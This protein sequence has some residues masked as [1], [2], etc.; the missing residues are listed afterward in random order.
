MKFS[1]SIT[2]IIFTLFLSFGAL[3]QTEFKTTRNLGFKASSKTQ[4][5]NIKLSENTTALQLFINCAVKKGSVSIVIYDPSD[6]KQ[7]EFSVE[8][9]ESED[10][11]SLFSMLKDG[12]TGQINK[13]INKPQ[14]G[15]WKIVFIPINATGRVEIQSSQQM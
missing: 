14:K 4:S 11:G 5:V 12:V 13:Y 10:D 3:A 1:K 8:S 7:G 15:N 9:I 6:E 2:V